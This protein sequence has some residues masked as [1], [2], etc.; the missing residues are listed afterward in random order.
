[1]IIYEV[2]E[3][4][5]KMQAKDKGKVRKGKQGKDKEEREMQKNLE[6]GQRN[7][8]KDEDEWRISK[9]FV[10]CMHLARR[11]HELC[12]IRFWPFAYDGCSWDWKLCP[13]LCVLGV[14][15]HIN[16]EGY[17]ANALDNVEH[18]PSY[19]CKYGANGTTLYYVVVAHRSPWWDC[20]SMDN[21]A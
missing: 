11:L 21:L 4:V 18:A 15:V 7:I 16:P 12:V 17:G 2:P 14:L 13:H 9:D 1:M 5:S 10:K 8:K 6:K 20:C 19:A 3:T